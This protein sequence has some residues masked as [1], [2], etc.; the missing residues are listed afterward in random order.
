MGTRYRPE[1]ARGYRWDDPAFAI[2]WPAAPAIISDRDAA[3]PL[4]DIGGG[5]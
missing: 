5:Q 2:A 3:Y 4:I 1:S